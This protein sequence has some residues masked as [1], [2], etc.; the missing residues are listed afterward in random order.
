M[1]ALTL[2]D[3]RRIALSALVGLLA[4]AIAAGFTAVA[5]LNNPGLAVGL[6]LAVAFV[7][8][9]LVYPVLG[10]SGALLAVPLELVGF[11]VGGGS[12]SPAE[13]AFAFTGVCWAARALL[14]PGADVLPSPRDL[15]IVVLLG[16]V[17]TG[18][19]M[20]AAEPA[21]VLRVFVLW[22]LFYAIYL[23]IQSFS[24]RQVELV[25]ASLVVGTGVLG[26]V[27]G[28]T[29][30]SSDVTIYA[31]G[32]LTER[33]SGTF[34]DPNYFA[35]MLLLGL[36][37]GIALAL[38]DLKRWWW[39][40]VPILGAAGGVFASVSRGALAA[41]AVGLMVLLLWRRARWIAVT[42]VAVFALL[43][44][45]NLNPALQSERVTVVQDRL[46]TLGEIGTQ[47]DLRPRL[48]GA[49][50]EIGT[51][52]PFF[53]VGWSGFEREANRRGV[54]DSRNARAIENVHNIPLSF[55]AETGVI[56][57]AAFMTWMAQ[58]AVRGAAALRSKRREVSV[59]ALGF[60]AGL[61]SFLLQGL[62]QMQLRV[63]VVA[64]A[65]F[66]VA[67]LLTN[68]GDLSRSEQAARASGRLLE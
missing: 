43:T 57:L 41:F 40:I 46:A 24:L 21:R 17:A 49:A 63:P 56:G 7:A 19:V 27:G 42:L 48:W 29:F 5:Y 6:I 28:L 13:A 53:G 54:F 39:L 60:I 67:G 47:R 12:V 55:L 37:P 26:A 36:L 66:V 50:L 65:F 30:L 33:A 35:S 64:A 22:T 2:L 32:T 9:A 58:L 34:Q 23:Q 31:D 16:F 62:T 4:V 11:E 44:A 14:R 8:L 68:L 38:S 18:L 51:E 45:L 3:G 1:S 15:P 61:V 25:A 20:D 52:H 10:V 59:L